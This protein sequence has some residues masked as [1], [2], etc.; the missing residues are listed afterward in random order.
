[1]PHGLDPRRTVARETQFLE[2]S[3][4]GRLRQLA[5]QEIQIVEVDD[6]GEWR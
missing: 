2:A 4:P 3:A 6:Q 5:Q 1:M